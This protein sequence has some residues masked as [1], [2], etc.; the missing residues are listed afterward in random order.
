MQEG[1]GTGSNWEGPAASMPEMDTGMLLQ[2]NEDYYLRIMEAEKQVSALKEEAEKYKRWWLEAEGKIGALE[3]KV[4]ATDDPAPAAK[5]G[6]GRPPKQKEVISI[7]NGA[8]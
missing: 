7:G 6:R 4:A 5:R 3:G 2:V 8:F 1:S